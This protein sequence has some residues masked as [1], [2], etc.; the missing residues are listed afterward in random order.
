MAGRI[1]KMKLAT[2]L[3]RLQ[4]L[5]DEREQALDRL[6]EIDATLKD[7]TALREARQRAEETEGQARQW[8]VQQRDLELQASSLKQKIASSK[9][10]LY[11]GEVTNPKELSDLQAEG[12]SLK[13][14]LERVEEEILE[15]MIAREGA[16]EAAE[17]A[18]QQ[19]ERIERQRAEQGEELLEERKQL[20]ER[21]AETARARAELVSSIPQR[22]LQ[23][24]DE[25]RRAKRGLAV[26]SV[27]GK[28]CTGC[29]MEF[30]SAKLQRARDEELVFCDNC[31]RIL[32]LQK[33]QR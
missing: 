7:D 29:G 24:Y 20:E 21:L 4:Q 27:R 16:E 23:A 32:A 18:R 15:T 25:I 17:K 13:E 33:P 8:A 19:L 1:D 28:A 10:R 12:V 9:K 26:V 5:D 2:R 11:S 3:Y 6:S 31:G 22:D 14:R 30:P